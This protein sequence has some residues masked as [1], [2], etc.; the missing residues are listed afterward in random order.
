MLPELDTS[1]PIFEW[2]REQKRPF[3]EQQMLA[4]TEHHYHHCEAYRRFIDAQ[5]PVLPQS[6]EAI[7]LMAAEL[8]KHY[9]L[10]SVDHASRFKT[11]HSSGTT[12]TSPSRIILDRETAQLQSRVL[13]K[14]LQSLLGDQRLPMLIADSNLLSQRADAFAARRAGVQGLALFGR[15]HRYL[16]NDNMQLDEPALRAF[17]EQYADSSVLMF[18]FTFMV[19]LHLLEPLLKRGLTFPFKKLFLLHSGGWKQMQDRAVSSEQFNEAAQS[20]FGNST[21]VHNFYGMVEQTGSIYLQCEQGHLH[22]PLYADIRIRDPRNFS[23]LPVGEPGLIETLSLL[24]RSYPGHAL[25]TQDLGRILGED[26]CPCGR[27]GHYFELF[28]RQQR[29]EV[30]GCSDTYVAA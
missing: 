7:P 13:G 9:D 4:L 11:L 16:L 5:C 24:P 12:G 22:A 19:W 28:G 27:K 14:I 8:F 15:D 21:A 6:L 30:R 29:A 20:L 18:G 26:D 25:L 2:C 17:A 23:L 1:L 3:F 10:S